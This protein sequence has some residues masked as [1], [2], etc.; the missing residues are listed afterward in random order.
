MTSYLPVLCAAPAAAAILVASALPEV[1]DS[2]VGILAVT[3][4]ALLAMLGYALKRMFNIITRELRDLR[5]AVRRC[6][7]NKEDE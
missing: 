3:V 4:S 2:V 6:P 5:D 7:H 1:P